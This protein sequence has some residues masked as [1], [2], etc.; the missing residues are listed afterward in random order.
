MKEYKNLETLEELKN[1]LREF[2]KDEEVEVYLFGSR[3]KGTHGKHSDVDIAIFSEKDL[4]DRITVLREI[5][6]ESN[7]P[8]EVDIVDLREAGYLKEIVKREGER[9]I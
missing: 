4:S 1:F 6:E 3:A 5:L 7:L 2:F 9:W 8:Y